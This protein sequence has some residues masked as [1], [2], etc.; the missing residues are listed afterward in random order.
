MHVCMA[1]IRDPMSMCS[2]CLTCP[3]SPLMLFVL[4]GLLA[5]CC[6]ARYVHLQAALS[7]LQQP[8][9]MAGVA[10][11]LHAC[12]AFLS[13]AARLLIV[14]SSSCTAGLQIAL[15]HHI[16]SWKLHGILCCCLH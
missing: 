9:C 14:K 1:A 13:V 10:V 5:C 8:G 3:I 11:S 2:W 6:V 7:L 15:L 12:H 16:C 4:Y